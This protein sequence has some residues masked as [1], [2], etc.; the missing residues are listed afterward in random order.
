M[1]ITDKQRQAIKN[2]A[3]A[4]YVPKSYLERLDNLTLQ[5]ASIIIGEGIARVKDQKKVD[6]SLPIK[7]IEVK[8][9][10]KVFDNY[11]KFIKASK[12]YHEKLWEYQY[13]RDE[14]IAE[15]LDS[16][17]VTD[18]EPLDVAEMGGKY[19]DYGIIFEYKPK[20][21]PRPKTAEEIM[22]IEVCEDG[23]KW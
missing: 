11:Y 4:G 21:K 9:K 12:E 23:R 2:M 10:H 5:E 1:K 6:N 13:T 20:P 16:I 19:R 15:W 22:L 3:K 7:D 8:Q 14:E 17:E 18:C